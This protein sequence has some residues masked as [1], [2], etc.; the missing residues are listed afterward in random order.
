MFYEDY[1]TSPLLAIEECERVHVFSYRK[2]RGKREIFV[3]HTKG[4]SFLWKEKASRGCSEAPLF[5]FSEWGLQLLKAESCC[6]ENYVR[7]AQCKTLKLS[8][9]HKQ[10]ICCLLLDDYPCLGFPRSAYD[11]SFTAGSTVLQTIRDRRYSR[12]GGDSTT[13]ILEIWQFE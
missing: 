1:E 4:L 2:E 12:S 11:H 7:V 8:P 13:K 9:L 10:S 3:F 6:F 5:I